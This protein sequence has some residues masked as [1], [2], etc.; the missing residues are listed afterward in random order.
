M[1]GLRGGLRNLVVGAILAV[2]LVL[3]VLG[4]PL[5][6]LPVVLLGTW[7]VIQ[8]GRGRSRLVVDQR[9]ADREGKPQI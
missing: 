8:I 7:Q 3:M 5:L 1:R 2:G 4:H 9:E 6:G